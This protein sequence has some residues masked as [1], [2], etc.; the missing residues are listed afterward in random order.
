MPRPRKY[1]TDADRQAAHRQR[2]ATET[3][4]VDRA[5]V[6]ELVAAVE[7]AAA[8]G[9]PVARQVRTAGVD[10]L[11]RNLGHHFR[12]VAQRSPDARP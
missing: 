11:L 10:A 4:R 7:T 8:A 2:Q 3:L 9:D 1:S 5:A 6:E 12:Q